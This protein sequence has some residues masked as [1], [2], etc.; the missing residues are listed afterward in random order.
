MG[1]I[2][3]RLSEKTISFWVR[4]VLRLMAWVILMFY[5]VYRVI[6]P[7]INGEPVFLD[8]NDGYVMGGCMVLLLAIEAVRAFFVKYLENKKLD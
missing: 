5:M 8:K 2:K 6:I 3:E 1:D 4:F 7:L